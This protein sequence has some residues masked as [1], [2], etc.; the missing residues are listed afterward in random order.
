MRGGSA[1][2]LDRERDREPERE[3]DRDDFL[4]FLDFLDLRFFFFLPSL[5]FFSFE[6]ALPG[7]ASGLRGLLLRLRP[8]LGLRLRLRLRLQERL[9]LRLR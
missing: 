4:D 3:P 8:R 1:H 5:R 2:D 6:S 7:S 9:R